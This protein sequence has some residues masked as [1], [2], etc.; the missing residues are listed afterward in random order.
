MTDLNSGFMITFLVYLLYGLAFIVLCQSIVTRDLSRS[1][2]PLAK[3]MFLLA[4][5]GFIHGF[6]EWFVL[7]FKIRS[8]NM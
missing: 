5:F 2:L 7:Y 8:E 6:H 3:Y 1:K 4:V